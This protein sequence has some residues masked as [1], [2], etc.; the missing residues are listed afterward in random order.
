M[1]MAYRL[2]NVIIYRMLRKV[3]FKKHGYFQLALSTIGASLGFF[4]LL[5][6]IQFYIDLKS[7]LVDKQQMATSDFLVLHKEVGEMSMLKLKN[8]EFTREEIEEIRQQ[9]YIK[10]VGELKQGLFEVFATLKGVKQLDMST[11]MYFEAIDDKFIDI[12]SSKWKWKEGDSIVP[13]ILP[14][15]LLESYNFGMAPS[16]N[17]PPITEKTLTWFHYGLRISGNGKVGYFKG[18]ILGFSDRI[19]TIL[20]PKK[21]IE[22]ANPIFHN[23]P[24]SNPSQLVIEVDD[25]THPMLA[26]FL[27]E[28]NYVTNKDKLRSSRIKTILDICLVVFLILGLI[29]LFMAALTFIQYAHLSILRVSTELKNVMAIGYHYT[30]PAR[31][32]LILFIVLNLAALGIGLSGVIWFKGQLGAYFENHYF[33]VEPGLATTTILT[34]FGAVAFLF[35]ANVLSI[36]RLL[37]GLAR[38]L[39]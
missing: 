9:P 34:S 39:Q 4:V 24:E 21:F 10:E 33:T 1:I 15:I 26:K 28:K 35:T 30:A 5:A 25:I 38:H 16:Q 19:N 36:Y 20:V 31:V 22:W 18:I 37:R 17:L 14:S 32:F 13:I 29:I 2:T 7:V 23:R 27:K 12:E 6:G 3:I 8:N 11:A